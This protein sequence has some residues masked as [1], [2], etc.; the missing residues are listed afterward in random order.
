[1]TGA[2]ATAVEGDVEN[3]VEAPEDEEE[4]GETN[5]APRPIRPRQKDRVEK[6]AIKL[7]ELGPRMTLRLT[8]IEEGLCAGKTMWH[9]FIHKTKTE[10]K[11]LDSMW[12]ERNKVKEKRRAEQKANV[13]R[14]KAT[15]KA[16]RRNS[17]KGD[18][19]EGADA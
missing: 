5:A 8:K 12:A 7:V 2:N 1:M 16:T 13:E 19:G 3:S 11:K 18:E 15:Q 6:R 10:E 4:Q 17:K 9:E 14:K